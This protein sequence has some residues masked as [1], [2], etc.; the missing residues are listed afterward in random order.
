MPSF[1][2]FH[3]IVSPADLPQLRSYPLI[4]VLYAYQVGAGPKL[5]RSCGPTTLRGGLLGAGL[6]DASPAGDPSQ[7]CRQA[8]LECQSRGAAGIFADWDRFSRSLFQFTRTLGHSLERAGLILT[9]PEAYAGVT[10][11]ARVLISSALSGGTLEVRLSEALERHGPDRTVLA[12]QRMREDFRLPSPSGR[13]KLLSPGRA[14]RPL[15]PAAGGLLVLRAVRPVFYLP[16]GRR[17][18]FCA[19]RRRRQPAKKAGACPP[20]GHS[21]RLRRLVGDLRLC[22]SADRA[23]GVDQCVAN[24][25]FQRASPPLPADLPSIS[26]QH[27]K[28]P[29]AAASGDRHCCFPIKPAAHG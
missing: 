6:G 8:V 12:L 18:P 15:R 23:A 10:E 28:S 13:G 1:A 9:V 25:A 24:I 7:F 5:L 17:G 22:G 20:A 27:Q 3:C 19:L 21:S 4:P 16:G 2:S 29:D 14:V 11:K 26:Y